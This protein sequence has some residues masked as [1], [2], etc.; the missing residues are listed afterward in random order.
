MRIKRV[1]VQNYRVHRDTIVD[2]DE[3]LTLISGHNE[4]GKSTLVEA[5]H[6]G[7]FLRARAGG[8]LREQMQ[9]DHGGFPRVEIE[10][11]ADGLACRA[12]KEFRGPLGTT[13]LHLA[14][15]PALTGDAAEE[16]LAQLLGFAEPIA[17]PGAEGTLAQRWAHLWAWQGSSGGDPLSTVEEQ[18]AQLVQRLQEIGGGAVMQSALDQRLTVRFQDE[19]DELFTQAGK[20]RANSRLAQALEAQVD[21][22]KRRDDAAAR[23]STLQGAMQTHVQACDQIARLTDSLAHTQQE[24]NETE[25]KLSQVNSLNAEL[26]PQS[27]TADGLRKQLESLASAEELI[28][29]AWWH[30][31]KVSGQTAEATAGEQTAKAELDGVQTMAT[32]AQKGTETAHAKARTAR[33]RRDTLREHVTG[34]EKC[35]ELDRLQKKKAEIGELCEGL[36]K[37]QQEFAGLPEI[38]NDDVDE[39]GAL[40]NA[41]ALA[42]TRLDGMAA[43]IRVIQASDGIFVDGQAIAEGIDTIVTDEAKIRIGSGNVLSVRPGGG[44]ALDDLRKDEATARERFSNRLAQLKAADIAAASAIAARRSDIHNQIELG[45]AKL[46]A[47]GAE[48]LEEK[49]ATTTGEMAAADVEATRLADMIDGGLDLPGDLEQARAA[50]GDADASVHESES[51]ETAATT[52]H[53][54]WQRRLDGARKTHT[55]AKTNLSNLMVDKGKAEGHLKGLVD[56]HGDEK[57]REKRKTGL[58]EQLS[59][60]E[61]RVEK[62][63][64][65]LTQLQPDVLAADKKRLEGAWMETDRQIKDATTRRI[66]SEVLLKTE[67]TLDPSAALATANAELERSSANARTEQN[68]AGAIRRLAELFAEEQA[69]LA[70]QFTE[71]LAA[72]ARPY[73]D[74]LFSPGC[75]VS[76]R[77]D[78]GALQDLVVDRGSAG[79]GS[80]DFGDLSAGAREQVGVAM[81]LAMAEVLANGHGGALPIALD[82]AFANSDPERVKALWRVLYYAA[83]RGLQVIVLSCNPSDYR[84]LGAKE[85]VLATPSLTQPSGVHRSESGHADGGAAI[86]RVQAGALQSSHAPTESPVIQED[87]ANLLAALQDM[88]GSSGNKSLQ[89]ALGWDAERYQRVQQSLIHSGALIQGRGRGGSVRLRDADPE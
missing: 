57:T 82:D 88:G 29:G 17:G 55:D 65:E 62:L 35:A 79:L 25:F 18:N 37:L 26:I 50:K 30:L 59:E 38:S 80:F 78:A 53:A 47:L 60:I 45:K 42:K 63:K 54:E 49:L 46:K 89:T 85:V 15:Q 10:F 1:R 58:Q 19:T 76:I 20:P 32:D 22:G 61:A 11:E 12:S 4:S 51:R 33:L 39:L 5:I 83:D 64:V 75:A 23:V 36:A 84:G 44:Q 87:S 71:P 16:R 40:Q 68:H 27:E 56:T 2:L 14:G 6:R 70:R 43:R 67:G 77:F 48:E 28:A 13:T 24:W 31:G 41:H 66:E 21:A 8:K 3:K 34:L 69:T 9:S 81:R 7:L 86:A 73:L 72:T 52:Q 74:R